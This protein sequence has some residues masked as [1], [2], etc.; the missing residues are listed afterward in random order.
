MHR[1]LSWGLSPLW[2]TPESVAI[3]PASR[4]PSCLFF[5]GRMLMVTQCVLSFLLF[6]F[7]SFFFLF[8]LPCLLGLRTF[9]PPHSHPLAW[10]LEFE[11][12]TPTLS[13]SWR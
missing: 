9:T 3:P 12:R 4:P 1:C 11:I 7:R 6:S 8:M 2:G 5:E 13:L 10:P